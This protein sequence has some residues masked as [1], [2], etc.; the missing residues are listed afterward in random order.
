MPPRPV[1]LASASP[2]R[3]DLLR[4]AGLVFRVIPTEVDET[5]LPGEDPGDLAGRLA[6]EKAA[7]V[8]PAAAGPEAIVLAADTVVALDAEIL[9]KPR[10]LEDARRMLRRLA[11]RTH[12]VITG[13]ALR[14]LP[15]GSLACDRSRSRV[16]FAPM[17]EHEISWY[18]KSG[19]G[20]DKAGAY[21]LQGKGALFVRSIEGSYTNVIGLPL[22]ILY[23]MLRRHGLPP[24]P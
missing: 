16:T 14:L 7:A 6:A 5:P 4:L 17:D 2:R 1:V 9:G 24:L 23:P 10:D 11:G 13:I 21:A 3:A 12:E 22:E 8:G 19:E 20:M 15:E 18:A